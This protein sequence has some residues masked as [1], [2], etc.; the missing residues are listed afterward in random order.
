[1]SL[2]KAA[3]EDGWHEPR[4][5]GVNVEEAVFISESCAEVHVFKPSQCFEPYPM[6][7]SRQ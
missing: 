7:V 1:M 4:N 2:W 5:P 6:S 3:V